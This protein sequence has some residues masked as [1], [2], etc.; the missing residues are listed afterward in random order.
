MLWNFNIIKVV[1][2]KLLNQKILVYQ[3]GKAHEAKNEMEEEKGKWQ[4]YW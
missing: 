4:Q 2:T 3:V 1:T